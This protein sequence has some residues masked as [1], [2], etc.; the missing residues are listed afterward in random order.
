[1]RKPS[2]SKFRDIWNALEQKQ[3]NE[4]CVGGSCSI[5]KPADKSG[6]SAGNKIGKPSTIIG[7]NIKLKEEDGGGDA[8]GDTSGS[9]EGGTDEEQGAGTS[10]NDVALFMGRIGAGVF[11]GKSEDV[12]CPKGTKK[13]DGVC[14]VKEDEQPVTPAQ[15]EVPATDKAEEKPKEDAAPVKEKEQEIIQ[16]A[17]DI[18]FAVAVKYTIVNKNPQ[19]PFDAHFISLANKIEPGAGMKDKVTLSYEG[20]QKLIKVVEEMMKTPPAIPQ[21]AQP[22]QKP[23]SVEVPM[24]S[25][26]RN[27]VPFPNE[28]KKPGM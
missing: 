17:S 9:T 27:M 26:D 21:V 12:K 13:K 5:S 18:G 23:V 15:Q 20:W 7:K 24:D 22:E 10:T 11:A 6:G 4:S 16:F 3:L 19:L 14:V 8:G 1:M 2:T 28:F 25:A